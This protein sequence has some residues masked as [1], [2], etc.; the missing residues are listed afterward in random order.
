MKSKQNRFSRIAILLAL[1]LVMVSQAALASARQTGPGPSLQAT[2]PPTEAPTETLTETPTATPTR[3]PTVPS[4]A[5]ARPQLVVKRA[6]PAGSTSIQYGQDFDLSVTLKNSGETKAYNIQAV[7]TPGDLI[8]RVNGGVV[9]A[10]DLPS[11]QDMTFKQPMTAEDT[12]WGQQFAMTTM[13][14]TYTDAQDIAYT[15]TFNISIPLTAPVTYGSSA[16]PTAISRPQ[17]VITDYTTSVTPLEPGVQFT[18]QL[19]VT[20]SGTAAARQVVM[21]AGGGSAS[22]GGGETPAPGGISGGSGSFATFAPVG[23]S[24]VQSLGDVPQASEI[25][26]DQELIVNVSVSPGAYPFPISFSYVD[27]KGNPYT[28]DQVITLLV[29]NLPYVDI[30]FYRDPNPIL[31]GQ[32]NQLPLQVVNLGKSLVVLGNMRVTAASGAIENGQ[33]LVG[34]LDAGGYFTLDSTLIPDS[35]GSLEITVSVD[36]TDDFNEPR[37]IIQV[38]TVE[39]QE[40][41]VEPVGPGIGDG[42][43]IPSEPAPETFWQR[44]QRFF[45]GLLGLDSAPESTVPEGAPS[46]EAPPESVPV[47]PG[48]KG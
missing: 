24:N 23:A 40:G 37:T 15:D 29:Y 42:G 13:T 22:T 39:V 14:L 16:T 20:N 48:P 33:A 9:A 34:P 7:F 2:D 18:L 45:A 27:D 44:V 41:F 28:D 19:T 6:A 31:A 35:P 3:T 5:S 12:L 36:Y 30:S 1:M 32:P 47:G 17:L 38:L 4:N 8:P 25:Q 26:A 46:E 21:I 11:G 10:G 43:E